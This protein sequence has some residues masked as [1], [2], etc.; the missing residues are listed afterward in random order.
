MTAT[1]RRRNPKLAQWQSTSHKKAQETQ[2]KAELSSKQA[3]LIASFCV[4]CAFLRPNLFLSS[5]LIVSASA[6][7]VRQNF[8]PATATMPF[9]IVVTHSLHPSHDLLQLSR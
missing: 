3:L 6:L 5:V 2:K 4:S 9:A 8:L 7:I 1:R